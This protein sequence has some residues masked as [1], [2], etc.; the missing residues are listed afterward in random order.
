M[1]FDKCPDCSGDRYNDGETIQC[2]ECGTSFE[3]EPDYDD[4]YDPD[5]YV[6]MAWAYPDRKGEGEE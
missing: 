3:I 1:S 5:D 6:P 2:L 4:E